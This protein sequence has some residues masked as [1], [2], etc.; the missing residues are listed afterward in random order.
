MKNKN[1]MLRLAAMAA[2]C[3]LVLTPLTNPP[4]AVFASEPMAEVENKENDALHFEVDVTEGVGTHEKELALVFEAPAGFELQPDL[5]TWKKTTGKDTKT[6]TLDADRIKALIEGLEPSNISDPIEIEDAEKN[7]G[8]RTVYT[9]DM[10]GFTPI[11]STYSAAQ[12]QR[13]RMAMRSKTNS[14]KKNTKLPAEQRKLLPRKEPKA[15][16]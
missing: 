6:E 1:N 16:L 7:K 15:S 13:I 8:L 10:R 14:L 11:P 12:L 9:Y 3:T 2:S 4:A 5:R